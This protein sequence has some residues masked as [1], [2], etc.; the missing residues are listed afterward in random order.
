LDKRLDL[1][2]NQ[3]LA[4]Q[5]HSISYDYAPE[6]QNAVSAMGAGSGGLGGRGSSWIFIHG[7]D[8]VDRGLIVLIFG[9]FSV[10]PLSLEEA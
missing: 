2:K 1:D 5:K 7:T 8:I 9:L 3:N 4:S 10:A 6:P